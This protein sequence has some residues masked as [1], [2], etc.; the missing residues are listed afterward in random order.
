MNWNKGIPYS[1]KGQGG[2]ERGSKTDGAQLVDN[3]KHS[4]LE[5]LEM[6]QFTSI[7]S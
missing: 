2:R 3:V 4:S 6:L 1:V 5:S 7:S